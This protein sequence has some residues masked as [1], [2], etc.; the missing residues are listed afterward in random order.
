MKVVIV[1]DEILAAQHLEEILNNLK[2]AIHVVKILHTVKE[3]IVFFRSNSNFDLIF[4]DIQLGDG[5]CFEIFKKTKPGIPVIFCTAYNQYAQEAFK[6][7]G[8]DYILKPFTDESI[9]ES[10]EK[11]RNL[12]ENF[13]GIKKDYT[14]ILEILTSKSNQPGIT[15][16]LIN[17]KGKIIPVRIKEIALFDIAN[18]VTELINFNNEKYITNHNLDELQTICGDAFYRANRQYLVNRNAI[19]EVEQFYA[20]KLLIKLKIEGRHEI[21]IPKGK[22]ADFLDW[23]SR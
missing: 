11:Y 1:E 13:T 9:E 6:N 2:P 23:L 15:S 21:V 10:I 7:N 5:H 8:I 17:F 3:A 16:L 12:K 20:R 19:E 4:C 14:N 22:A 18:K